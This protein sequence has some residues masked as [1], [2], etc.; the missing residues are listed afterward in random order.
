MM[1]GRVAATESRQHGNAL[2]IGSD[3]SSSPRA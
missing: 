3:S 1:S 2:S